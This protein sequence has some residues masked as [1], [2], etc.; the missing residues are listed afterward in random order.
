M[1]LD[2]RLVALDMDGTI[3]ESGRAILPE[4]AELLRRLAAE[5]VRCTTATGRPVGFQMEL[6]PRFGLGA[7]AG[8]PHALMADERELFWLD[9]GAQRYRP[10][11]PWNDQVRTWWR[12]LHPVA[13]RWLARAKEEAA[14]QGWDAA[15]L[16]DEHVAYERGLPTL[17]CPTAEQAAALRTWLDAQ[18]RESEPRL[19]CNRNVRLVQIQDARV[20]K[21]NVLVE[22]ARAWGVAPEQVLAVGDSANDFSMLDGAL[23]LR[24]ATVGNADESIKT[25]VRRAGGIVAGARVGSGVVEILRTVFAP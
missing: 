3:L 12:A 11:K 21:G 23:G 15:D 2:V 18:L 19:H 8:A 9:A 22:L 10:L 1:P 24:C 4:L 20:G 14:R 7:R 5:G 25:V 13:I 16:M 17:H 6:F